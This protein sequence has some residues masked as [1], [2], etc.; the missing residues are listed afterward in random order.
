MAAKIPQNAA[1]STH[2]LHPTNMPHVSLIVYLPLQRVNNRGED[3]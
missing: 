1:D 2:S 3:Q